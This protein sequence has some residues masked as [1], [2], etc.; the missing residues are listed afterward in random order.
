MLKQNDA[1][2]RYRPQNINLSILKYLTKNT[3]CLSIVSLSVFGLPE[4]KDGDDRCDGDSD[5]HNSRPQQLHKHLLA[6]F[7]LLGYGRTPYAIGNALATCQYKYNI[8]GGDNERC[9]IVTL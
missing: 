1:R 9:Q 6:A 5:P 4:D 8:V 7:G 2:I 3:A